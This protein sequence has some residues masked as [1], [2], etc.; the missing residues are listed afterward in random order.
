M[1]AHGVAAFVPQFRVRLP[2]VSWVVPGDARCLTIRAC[3]RETVPLASTI[4]K[5]L[6]VHVNHSQTNR[7]LAFND[8][9]RSSLPELS[10][11]RLQLTEQECCGLQKRSFGQFVAREAMLDEEYWTAA[12]LR[13]EAHWESQPGMRNADAHKVKFAEREF[14]ALK[15]RCSGQEGNSLKCFCLVAVKKEDKNIRRTVLKSIVGTLDLSIRQ[16][17]SGETYPGR[18]KKYIK[19]NNGDRV[20]ASGKIKTEGGSKVKAD[21]TGIYRKWKERSHKKIGSSNGDEDNGFL[22]GYRGRGG[23]KSRGFG[24]RKNGHVPNAHVRSEIKNPDQVR[25]ERQKK[26]DRIT[27]LKT[28][29]NKGKKFGGKNGKRGK[30]RK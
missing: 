4:Q 26:A 14:Y 23:N 30:P 2:Q 13:T 1:D 29:P 12:W 21:K 7:Q 18:H 25:K 20:T 5:N 9:K 15:K 24:G 6:S 10:F 19:L 3:N 8:G 27:H 17:F 11:N 28:K 16:Y 22:G